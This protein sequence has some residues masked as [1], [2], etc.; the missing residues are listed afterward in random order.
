[1]VWASVRFFVRSR[2]AVSASVGANRAGPDTYTNP[3]ADPA[4]DCDADANS[5]ANSD[6][7]CYTNDATS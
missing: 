7:N 2:L 1:M 5:D 3:D 4:T 6:A